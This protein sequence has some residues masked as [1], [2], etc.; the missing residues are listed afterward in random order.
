MTKP[1][2][3]TAVLS[4]AQSLELGV[5]AE[6]VENQDQIDFLRANGCHT[7]QGYF[8]SPP[9]D[10]VELERALRGE[11]SARSLTSTPHADH[12]GL[13]EL[14][15][16]IESTEPGD[17]AHRW[18]KRRWRE[19]SWNGLRRPPGCYTASHE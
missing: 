13:M 18:A 6:G 10:E 5:I 3:A 17:Y 16:A 8:F 11:L 15:A 12:D 2:I 7:M 14:D 1:A 9:L 4:L 19:L